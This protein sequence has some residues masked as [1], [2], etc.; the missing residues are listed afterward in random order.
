MS[1]RER[2][3]AL[4]AAGFLAVFLLAQ[5]VKCDGS[6]ASNVEARVQQ[7]CR[8]AVREKVPGDGERFAREQVGKTTT[9]GH[10]VGYNVTGTV[11]DGGASKAFACTAEWDTSRESVASA[12]AELVG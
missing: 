4:V 1:S 10:L 12:V 8:D 11:A 2:L 3:V 5:V 6:T 7:A 9:Q